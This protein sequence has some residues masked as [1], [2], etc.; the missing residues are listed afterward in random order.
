MDKR[1]LE[2]WLVKLKTPSVL[3]NY[4]KCL[5]KV[6]VERALNVE[7]DDLLGCEK[8]SPRSSYNSRNGYFI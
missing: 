1:Y 3:D 5:T 2:F 4:R 8:R 7:F 6:A